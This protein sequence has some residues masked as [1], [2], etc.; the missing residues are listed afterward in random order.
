MRSRNTGSGL[1]TPLGYAGDPPEDSAEATGVV[2]PD[3]PGDLRYRVASCLQRS[4]GLLHADPLKVL[5][6][7]VPRC[8]LESADEVPGAHRHARGDLRNGELSRPLL[9][10]D[11]LGLQDSLVGV[12]LLTAEDRVRR[13]G[14][15]VGC[16]SGTSSRQASPSRP[17]STSPRGRWKG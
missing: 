15:L 17:R 2:V 1:G 8:T 4:L 3:L 10:D 11:H 5:D 13:L 7:L 6:W 14:T 9:L 16:R 12:R